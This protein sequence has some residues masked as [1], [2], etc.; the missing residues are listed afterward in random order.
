MA[1]P[2]LSQ[3]AMQLVPD[4]APRE[5]LLTSI[6]SDDKNFADRRGDSSNAA[7]DIGTGSS[8]SWRMMIGAIIGALLLSTAILFTGLFTHK[9]GQLEWPR[10]IKA[11]TR[12]LAAGPDAVATPAPIIVQLSPEMVRVTA[13]S[14]GHPRLAVINGQTLSEG[15]S[16]TVSKSND[17]VALTLR[18][19]KIS[20]G[21][22]DLTDGKNLFSARIVIQGAGQLTPR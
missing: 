3:I 8:N 19:V 14:L 15:E 17:A 22:I 18:V 4:A 21:R 11:R 16:V 7:T 1:R 2:M 13:I 20:D 10:F 5:R 12:S 9:D 6:E